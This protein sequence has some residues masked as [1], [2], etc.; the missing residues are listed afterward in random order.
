MAHKKQ[1]LVE[2][3]KKRQD[4]GFGTKATSTQA[5]LVKADGDFNVIKLGQSFE[6][7]LN[8]YHRLI[9]MHW[10]RFVGLIFAFYI[11]LN[12]IFAVIY[13]AIGIEHLNGVFAQNG[14]TQ[15]Q[16]AFFFSSQT[17]TTVGYGQISPTGFLTSMI[18]AIEALLGLMSFA[19][20]TGL[21]Y[22]RFSR[23]TPFIKF[24]KKAL[25]SPYLDTNA[26][27]FRCVNERSNQLMNVSVSIILSRNEE[28]KGNLIRKYYTLD[29][30]REKVK[31]FPMSWTIVHPITKGSPLLGQTPESLAAS[32]SE[33][34]VALEGTNDTLSDPIYA[35][36]SYLYS[37]LTWGA[38]FQSILETEGD[39][40][41]LKIQD[42]DK[43]ESAILNE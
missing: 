11:L 43:C 12:F 33:I 42:I 9:T 24:S 38:K 36:H 4:F 41:I 39:A 8:L 7:K 17:L 13:Y 10:S 31:F 21:L 23:P 29:L 18:A 6:V 19:I 30:E 22:G 27:M 14:L 1:S 20:M 35:R 32:D 28:V 25:I 40:Y 26:L 37:E 3:E 16:E 15:F 34:V 2:K 5:R